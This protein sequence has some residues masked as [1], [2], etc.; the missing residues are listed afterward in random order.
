[1]AEIGHGR[2]EN[3]AHVFPL[4]VYW[5]DTDA[6]GIVYYANYLKFIE[7]GRTEM[8]RHAGVDQ[9]AILETDGLAFAV[10]AV[11]VEYLR[12]AKLE[13]DIE[14]VTRVADLAGASLVLDQTVRRDAE[15]LATAAVRIA[16]IDRAGKPRRLPRLLTDAIQDLARA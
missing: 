14:I 16:C 12:P 1:M 13:D 11:S 2:I 3:G 7:R 4:R 6:A 8:L 9:Q 10:R 15:N 5:E